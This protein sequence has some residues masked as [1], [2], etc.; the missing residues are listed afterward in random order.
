MSM[1]D[2]MIRVLT[3]AKFE[4]RVTVGHVEDTV[5]RLLNELA[6]PTAGMLRG[7]EI[8]YCDV[9]GNIGLVTDHLERMFAP[10]ITAI[11]DGK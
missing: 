9:T 10:V 11:K 2:R 4:G 5:D 6:K 8:G 7:L 3:E 1:R